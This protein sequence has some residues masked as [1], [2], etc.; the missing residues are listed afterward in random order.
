VRFLIVLPLA[1]LLC[2]GNVLQ[3]RTEKLPGQT[4]S[5]N[6]YVSLQKWAAEKGFRVNWRR[7]D[8]TIT[9][10][11]KWAR[12]G[13]TLESRK[14]SINGITVWLSANLTASKTNLYI[15]QKDINSLFDPILF[16]P[17]LAKERRIRTVAICAGHGGKDP[18]SFFSKHQEKKYT[19]LLAK[20]IEEAMAGTG[21]KPL[22]IRSDDEYVHPEDQA[23]RANKMGADL[24]V[25]VH[26]NVAAEI[27]AKGLEVYCLT[28][29]GTSSTNGGTTKRRTQGNRNDP[30]NALLAYHVQKSILRDLDMQDRGL[31]HAAFLMLL[32]L[33]MPGIL[34]EGGF[35][36]NPSDAH[37]IFETAGRRKMARAIVDGVLEYKRLVER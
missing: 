32:E 22:M 37:K 31:K 25:T 16:P 10:T 33:N 4:A 5:G 8:Q 36:T 9:V 26:Y 18:G 12:L 34:I 27:E 2:S 13:F 3:A 17:K 6:R 23:F 28:P 1:L 14:A 7:G 21:L 15:T 19:L 24:F 35:M 30:F 29:E 20:E 11:N